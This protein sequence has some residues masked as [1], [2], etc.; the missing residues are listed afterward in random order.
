MPIPIRSVYKGRYVT[1]S[2]TY[3]I[4]FNQIL[5]GPID[6]CTLMIA[7][8]FADTIGLNKMCRGLRIKPCGTLAKLFHWYRSF[9]VYYHTAKHFLGYSF[10]PFSPLQ[11]LVSFHR[12]TS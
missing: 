12:P 3:S 7:D 4:L 5:P 6:Y 10:L 2:D 1:D 8:S 9:L 11:P